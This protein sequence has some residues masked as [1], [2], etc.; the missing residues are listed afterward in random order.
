MHE[1]CVNLNREIL[2]L[3]SE[4]I[5]PEWHQRN[6]DLNIIACFLQ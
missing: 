2:G 3:E 6:D 1:L 4:D 5:V